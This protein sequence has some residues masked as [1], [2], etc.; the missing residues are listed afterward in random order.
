MNTIM[1][2]NKKTQKFE[3]E[4]AGN[5]SI[6]EYRFLRSSDSRLSS[7]LS[8]EKFIENHLGIPYTAKRDK[9]KQSCA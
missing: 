8:S 6:R 7:E 2:F 9:R 1:K 3:V 4:K 5:P